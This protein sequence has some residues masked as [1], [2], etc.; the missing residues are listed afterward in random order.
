M[1]VGYRLIF[2]KEDLGKIQRDNKLIELLILQQH[3]TTYHTSPEY[4]STI[5]IF[6]NDYSIGWSHNSTDLSTI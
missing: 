2:M 4:K 5:D 6:L 1:V 3:N